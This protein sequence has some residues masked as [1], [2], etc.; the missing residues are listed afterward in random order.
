[1][2]AGAAAAGNGTAAYWTVVFVDAEDTLS[3]VQATLAAVQPPDETSDARYEEVSQVLDQAAAVVRSLRVATR[4]GE[5]GTLPEL[6]APADPLV[7]QLEQ[8]A[9][10]SP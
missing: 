7:G 5:L 1:M 2:A 6:A 4:R 8:Y 10:K 3:S 9:G